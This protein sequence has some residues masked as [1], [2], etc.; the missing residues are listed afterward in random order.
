MED[1]VEDPVEDPT[2]GDGSVG[3]S[4]RGSMNRELDLQKRKE[5]R[6]EKNI[7]T[8]FSDKLKS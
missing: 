5:Y 2:I 6:Q 8:C 7:K 3:E 4:V 1:P